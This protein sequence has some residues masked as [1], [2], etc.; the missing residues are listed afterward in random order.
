MGS[1]TTPEEKCVS[2]GFPNQQ[3]SGSPDE[4]QT[5][6]FNQAGHL[7]AS[8]DGRLRYY[9][10]SSWVA[11]VE[12]SNTSPG[13]DHDTPLLASNGRDI[14]PESLPRTSKDFIY[15]VDV[16]QLIAWSSG[17]MDAQSPVQSH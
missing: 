3:S 2:A 6:P 5:I 15:L 17:A 7:K 10:S 8:D 14:L 9:S 11:G 4:K 16:D 13:D 12:E 1:V